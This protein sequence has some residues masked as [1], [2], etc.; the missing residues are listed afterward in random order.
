M[1]EPVD[2]NML[3]RF[4]AQRLVS[5]VPKSPILRNAHRGFQPAPAANVSESGTINA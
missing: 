3:V 1:V 5:T 4:T 2:L